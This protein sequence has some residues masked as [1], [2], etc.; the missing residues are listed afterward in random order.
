MAG[1]GYNRLYYL[2]LKMVVDAEGTHACGWED[3]DKKLIARMASYPDWNLDDGVQVA[4]SAVFSCN[5][6]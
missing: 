6:M 2:A 1:S 3:P 4:A 5:C